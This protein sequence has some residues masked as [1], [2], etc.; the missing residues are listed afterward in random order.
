[1]HFILLVNLPYQWI[2]LILTK[3]MISS[4][5]THCKVAPLPILKHN[6]YNE[7]VLIKSIAV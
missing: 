7:V 5:T 4:L 1:M 6:A 2:S 3:C